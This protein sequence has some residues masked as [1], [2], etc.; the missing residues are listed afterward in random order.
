MFDLNIIKQRI[1]CVDVAQRLGLPI[2]RAGD[3]CKSP[4]RAGASNPTS[5]S[6]DTDFWYDFGDA[7]GGDVID[8]LAEIKYSGD[9]GQAIREL[10]QLTGVTNPDDTNSD[11]WLEYT[12]HLNAQTAYYHSQLTEDDRV[13]L[14][15]RGISDADS[16]RLLI[17]RVTDGALRGRLFI[18]YQH[19]NG[20]VAYYSTRAL[21]GSAFQENKYMKQK[22]DDHAQ[23]IPWGLQTLNRNNDTLVIAEGAFD[24]FSFEV[25]GYPVISAMTGFF[26]KD[27]IP[28]V[29][30]AAR[31]FKRVFII[32]DDD[33][34]T[35]NAGDKFTMRMSELLTRNRI[36]FIV[37]TIP[38][39]YHDVSEYF[40]AGGDLS[41]LITNAEHGITYLA[42]RIN[43]FSELEKFV[44]SVARHTKR[45]AMDELQSKLKNTNRWNDKSLNSLFKAATTA[46]PENIVAS[47]ILRS[48][49]IVYVPSVGFYEYS[50]GVWS[51]RS[52]DRINNYVDHAYGEFATYQRIKS[53]TGLLRNRAIREDI[54]FNA[55]PVWNFVNGTLELETGAFRDHNPNDYCSVQAAYPYNPDASYSAWTRFI[56]DVTMSDPK[57]SELLQLFPGYVL[58]PTNE[59]EKIFIF[60][61]SGGN[62]KTRY[63]EVLRQIFG[64][65]NI[66]HV[67]PRGL[68]KDFQRILL[69]SSILNVAG[70]IRS[71]LHDCEEYLKSIASGEPQTACYKGKDFITFIPRTKLAFAT[72]SQLSS[73]D[74]SDGLTRRLVMVDFKVSFVDNPDPN[75]PY[76]RQKNIRILD[77]ISTEI[78]SGG[79]FN[80]VYEGYK[81][82]KTVG[83]FTETT[84]QQELM[85]DFKRASNPILLFWEDVRSELRR[86]FS[87]YELYQKYRIWCEDNGE[88]PVT[89]NW[90][91]REFKNVASQVYVPYRTKK[92][93]GYRLKSE[94]GDGNGCK[95]TAR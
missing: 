29:V 90:F 10:A 40:A 88:K 5:F 43:E 16:D 47:E 91:H 35:S 38:P 72:N 55:K 57:A 51:K 75:N 3:R 65:E 20:Y 85:Q 79:V 67:T 69:R 18:P 49:Q 32:Y 36:P 87:N 61:G 39:P 26:S 81:L 2:Q 46:P 34:K 89:A 9:R 41:A 56:D 82:L 28:T 63:L 13:Y 17:G 70:E 76:Q 1:S 23:H 30:S 52:D 93:K 95:M 48:H 6:V 42:C 27:Q 50:S 64:D 14:R 22:R 21:P 94:N 11:G 73:G 7:R 68:L 78:Q 60:S 12:N 53:T 83:Y 58:F 80:W 4:L 25:S 45:T 84:D 59:H 71:D 86:E 33:S 24:A 15:S 8:L 92:Y 62:G 44:Y 77:D 54:A 31:K 37:G 66:S 74:T 19:P